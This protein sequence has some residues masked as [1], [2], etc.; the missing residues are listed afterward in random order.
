MS[1]VDAPG[2]PTRAEAAR[3]ALAGLRD[4]LR[5]APVELE[6]VPFAA[7]TGAPRTPDEYLAAP[8]AAAGPATDVL[9]ALATSS[10]RARGQNLQAL[11]LLSDGRPTQGALDPADWN[12]A[13]PVFADRFGDSLIG[14]D[15]QSAAA[16]THPWPMWRARRK[17][18]CG[19]KTAAAAG[20]PR[21]CGCA[22]RIATCFRRRITFDQELGRTSLRIPLEFR[23]AGRQRYKLLLDPLPGERTERN[24]SREI[25]IEVLQN[26]IRV[27]LVAARP[28][29]D[30]AFWARTLADDPNV[31]ATIVTRDA[32][33]GLAHRR[34]AAFP[35]AADGG[36]GQGLR[37][38]CAGRHGRRARCE[39]SCRGRDR[40]RARPGRCGAGGSRRR[41]RGSGGLHCA[42][43]ACCRRRAAEQLSRNS[44]QA[45]G[46]L[47]AA[48]APSS[49]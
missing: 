45:R 39:R 16:I 8:T 31:R 33:G 9:G 28:D 12:A 38:L 42:W 37:R 19:S 44:A 5:G 27:L 41:A 23:T 1:N 47:G 4:A 13:V 32:H 3:T 7:A 24:N 35:M 29:W 17:W 2:A 20:N 40:G 48:G 10:D 21:C 14:R 22:K 25:S 34:G 15:W 26:R 11:V 43:R 30:T 46:A 36:L 49:P 18:K 6:V